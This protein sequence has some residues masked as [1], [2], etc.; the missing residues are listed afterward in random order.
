MGIS[1]NGVVPFV[2]IAYPEKQERVSTRLSPR[3]VPPRAS[4][5]HGR[6]RVRGLLVDLDG[7]LY[8]GDEPVEGAPEALVN[9]RSSG[10]VLRYVTNTTRKPRREVSEHL[11]ALKAD[12]SPHFLGNVMAEPGALS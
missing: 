6:M 5:Y 1:R 2:W 8:V 7:T 3:V 4:G 12:L 9:L 11:R 10:L